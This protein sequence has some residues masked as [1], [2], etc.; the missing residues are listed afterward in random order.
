VE[1]VPFYNTGL[2]FTCTRCSGC[3]RHESG[4]V[5]LSENDLLRL[6]KEFNMNYSNFIQVWCRWIPFNSG[7][8]RLSLK[9]KS[10]YDCIF[11]KNG[12]TV[13]SARPLQCRTFPFW[14]SI[15]CSE[16]SWKNAGKSCPG[17]NS[18]EYHS[19]AEIEK[20]LRLLDNE[21]V[22]EQLGGAA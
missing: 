21:P 3:C 22:I 13:Y 12:C 14:D 15:M 2:N 17:I 20:F 7:R 16:E 11:W 8:E 18:G 5:Y 9:E 19:G 6:T 10:G 1:N 4:Y